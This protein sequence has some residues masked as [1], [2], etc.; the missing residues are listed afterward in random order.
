MAALRVIDGSAG[1]MWHVTVTVAGPRVAEPVIRAA[2]ERLS[3][4]HPFL[5]AGR[6]AAD[7]AEVRYWDEAA[8]ARVALTMAVDLW[9]EHRE[10]ASLPAW[11][12]VGVEVID[13]ETFHRRGRAAQQ[14]PEFVTAGRVLPF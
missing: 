10:S 13:Q 7:R 2:L 5:L 3:D 1:S 4:E 12:V 14:R 8:D 6:Y 11:Q 9:D